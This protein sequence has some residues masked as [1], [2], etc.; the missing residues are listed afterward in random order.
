MTFLAIENTTVLT[1]IVTLQLGVTLDSIHN[2][3]NIF[4][5]C[6]KPLDPHPLFGGLSCLCCSTL[7][8]SRREYA[9]DREKQNLK[10]LPTKKSKKHLLLYTTITT[11]KY[12]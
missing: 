5:L 6:P 7:L 9:F 8:I 2:H 10:Y 11:I 12:Y 1:F 3:C 4:G